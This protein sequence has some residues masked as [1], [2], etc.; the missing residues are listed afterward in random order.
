MDVSLF[1][2]NLLDKAPINYNRNFNDSLYIFGQTAL[3]PRTI[4]VTASY[5][6]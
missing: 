1:V 5:R 2:D 3:R 4:G 6:M